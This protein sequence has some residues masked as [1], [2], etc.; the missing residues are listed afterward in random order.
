MIV[1]S[2]AQEKLELLKEKYAEPVAWKSF[3][4]RTGIQHPI[5]VTKPAF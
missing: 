1:V 2:Q 5:F 3:L 4:N